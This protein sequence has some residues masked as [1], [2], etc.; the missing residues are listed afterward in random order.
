[1]GKKKP[2]TADAGRAARARAFT[3]AEASAAHEFGEDFD[4]GE[5]Y[6]DVR[7]QVIAGELSI[8]QAKALIIERAKQEAPM[9]VKSIIDVIG[10]GEASR[11]MGEA[12]A[13]A[14][15]ENRCL[16]LPE[17]VKIDGIWSRRYPDGRIEPDSPQLIQA[18]NG[19]WLGE[20]HRLDDGNWNAKRY[21][22]QFRDGGVTVS[23]LEEAESYI[24]AGA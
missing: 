11:L 19:E 23:T 16:G 18:A 9:G 10:R 3:Q 22:P 12:T 20:A 7:R 2:Q 24:R 6:R 15:E 21:G 14:A 4:P 8:D 17:A 13:A 1:M 5:T